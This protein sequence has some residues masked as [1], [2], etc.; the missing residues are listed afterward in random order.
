[1]PTGQD[2]DMNALDE[3][4]SRFTSDDL[5]RLERKVDKLGDAMNK[6]LLIEERQTN[7]NN[8][9]GAIETRV[10]IAETRISGSEKA[11]DKW[12][13]RGIGMWALAVTLWS[14]FQFYVAHPKGVL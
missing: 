13:N 5:Y 6:F 14:L 12:I 11:L 1:M 9:I 10:G 7:Q 2:S 3:A 8:R 4:K